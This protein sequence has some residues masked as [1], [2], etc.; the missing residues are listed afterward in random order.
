[1]ATSVFFWSTATHLEGTTITHLKMEPTSAA[2]AT[3]A[4]GLVED[5]LN[6]GMCCRQQK[7]PHCEG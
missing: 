5:V 3:A 4:E 7:K 2:A 6:E 1:L